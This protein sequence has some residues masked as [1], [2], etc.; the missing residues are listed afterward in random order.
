MMEDNDRVD[1]FCSYNREDYEE[2]RFVMHQLDVR[3]GI[4][5]FRDDAIAPGTDWLQRLQSMIQL[6]E[7]FLFFIR[8]APTQWQLRE[9]NLAIDLQTTLG[10][11][12][13]IPVLL[14]NLQDGAFFNNPNLAFLRGSQASQFAQSVKEIDVIDGLARAI[15]GNSRVYVSSRAV[16][17]S[18]KRPSG[19]QADL[20][21]LTA[22]LIGESVYKSRDISIRELIQNARDG[23]SRL[24]AR[25]DLGLRNPEIIVRIDKE[26]RF[27]DIID[28]GDGMSRDVLSNSFSVLGKSLNDEFHSAPGATQALNT[29]VTGKFG[30]GFISTFMIAERVSVSTLALDDEAH[31]FTIF[32]TNTP[33]HYTDQSECSRSFPDNGTTIRVWLKPD[34]AIGG[35]RLD[36]KTLTKQFCRHVPDLYLADGRQKYRVES[37]WNHESNANPVVRV[38]TEKFELRLAW[39]SAAHDSLL[40]SN[41]GFFVGPLNEEVLGAFPQGLITGEVN[42]APGLVDLTVSRDAVVSN[43]KVDRLRNIIGDALTQLLELSAA[44]LNRAASGSRDGGNAVALAPI[45]RRSAIIVESLRKDGKIGKVPI[46]TKVDCDKLYWSAL[47]VDLVRLAQRDGPQTY[48]AMQEGLAAGSI[49]IVYAQHFSKPSIFPAGEIRYNFVSLRVEGIDVQL[50][51]GRKMLWE[52]DFI[53]KSKPP[54]N[55]QLLDE[56]TAFRKFFGLWTWRGFRERWYEVVLPAVFIPLVLLGLYMIIAALVEAF[57]SR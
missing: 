25:R 51:N 32:D 52:G 27:F 29:P 22:L 33:F 36:I 17:R 50:P 40:L 20:G 23:C 3:G 47:L 39:A 43:E 55:V 56:D 48:T 34:Y 42:V 35:K 12:F 21:R 46:G 57:R 10:R 11:P 37:D 41:G 19:F 28:F 6:S 49:A 9:L 2:V 38:V 45:V 7:T 18:D 53:A 24:L 15:S 16:P 5:S 14:P 31:H 8:N 4:Q 26:N 13:I 54:G 30:I 44:S 1:A